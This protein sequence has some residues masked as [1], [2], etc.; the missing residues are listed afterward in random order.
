MD[1][2]SVSSGQPPKKR[3]WILMDERKI[4]TSLLRT[5]MSW[6]SEE[7]WC[8]GWLYNL[9]YMLWDVAIGKRRDVCSLEEAEQLK[10][11]SEKC[12]GWI[13][14]DGQEKDTTFVPIEEWLRLYEAH[15]DKSP[16]EKIK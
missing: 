4:T 5:L 9:E 6:I 16:E 15:S 12:G 14:W 7:R 1:G 13:I 2:V 11:L 3:S 10:Y 8:A